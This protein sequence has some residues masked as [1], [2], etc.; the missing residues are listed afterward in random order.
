MYP[1]LITARLASTRLPRKHLM[2]LGGITVIEHVIRRCEHFGFT[3]IVCVP[4]SEDWPI[5]VYKGNPVDLELRVTECAIMMDIKK[6]HQLD[7]DDP[8]FD[9][10]EIRLSMFQDDSY[11]KVLPTSTSSSGAASVGTSY[12]LSGKDTVLSAVN[13][14]LHPWP[15]RL[16]LDYAEDL[17]LLNAVDRMLGGCSW[18]APR[19]VIDDLFVRN[20]DLHKINW[21]RNIEWKER[22]LKEINKL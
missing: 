7:G 13:K 6:F 3:P 5:K 19:S 18:M 14:E 15:Q 4:E 16:T 1:V 20:P 2:K 9:E 8:F 21:F 10:R 12:N 22:Q 11:F 17:E